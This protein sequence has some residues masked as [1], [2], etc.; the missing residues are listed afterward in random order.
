MNK[1]SP[2]RQLPSHREYSDMAQGSTNDQPIKYHISSYW[3]VSEITEFPAILAQFGTDWKAIAKHVK[4]KTHVMVIKKFLN[5]IRIICPSFQVALKSTPLS[6]K[7]RL[8][9][10]TSVKSIQER[11]ENGRTLPKKPTRRKPVARI[12]D[13]LGRPPAVTPVVDEFDGTSASPKLA[14]LNSF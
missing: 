5:L 3:T 4:H 1:R 11:I 14:K 10:F 6:P 13:N 9:I 7:Y 8:R 2:K 12:L